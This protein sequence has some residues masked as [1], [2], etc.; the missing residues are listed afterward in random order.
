MGDSFRVLRSCPVSA[1][2]GRPNSPL[3]YFRNREW[4]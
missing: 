1:F 2:T 4:N 3:T